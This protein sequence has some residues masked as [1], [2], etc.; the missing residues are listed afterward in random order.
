MNLQQTFKTYVSDLLK[1]MNPYTGKAWKD[2]PTIAAWETGN[3]MGA[4]IGK[5]G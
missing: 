2:D 5:E 4:Y 3:E 1:H